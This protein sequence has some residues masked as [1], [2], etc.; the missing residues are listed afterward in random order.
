[1]NEQQWKDTLKQ[2]H[3]KAFEIAEAYAEKQANNQQA[4]PFAWDEYMPAK[5]WAVRS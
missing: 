5:G 1:M 4:K 3:Q 2:Q